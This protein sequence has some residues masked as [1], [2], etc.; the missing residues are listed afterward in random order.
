[1]GDEFLR[2][3][4]ALFVEIWKLVIIVCILCVWFGKIIS[5]NM[6]ESDVAPW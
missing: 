1:M 2:A 5:C 3:Y 6:K 4:V